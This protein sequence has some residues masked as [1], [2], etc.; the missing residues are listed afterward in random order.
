MTMSTTEKEQ[1]DN[2]EEKK[3][4]GLGLPD[5]VHV[6]ERWCKG[7]GICIAFC[8]EGVLEPDAIG[9]CTVANP[10]RCTLCKQC[11]LR[12]PDFAITLQYD[13][14]EVREKL[15]S[16]KSTDTKKEE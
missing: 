16:Q 3:S 4:H 5:P 11:E 10:E 15:R 6:Y 8:P 9:R 13:A 12:C 2:T 1:K 7:C 14:K